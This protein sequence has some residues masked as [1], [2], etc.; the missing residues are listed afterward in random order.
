M[1]LY[2]DP[3]DTSKILYGICVPFVF[4]PAFAI[5][6]VLLPVGYGMEISYALVS[7]PDF[8]H[9]GCIVT[10]HKVRY[11]YKPLVSLV[12]FACYNQ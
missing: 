2:S 1:P 12:G 8:S 3:E 4:F 9:N 7:D 6:I 11:L 10:N 5:S